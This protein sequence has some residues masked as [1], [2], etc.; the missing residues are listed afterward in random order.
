MSLPPE[1]PQPSGSIQV[2]RPA[3]LAVIRDA[4]MS[5]YGIVDL[6]PRSFASS[7]G[8]RLGRGGANRGID[9]E[10]ND[11]HLVIELSVVVEYGTPIFTVA[12]NVMKSVQFEAERVLGMTVDRVNVNVDGL[13]VSRLGEG[14]A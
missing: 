6:A 1:P 3:L 9:V 4:V 11:G 7:L 8:K 14:S 10:V 2:A 5:C 13:R 12:N